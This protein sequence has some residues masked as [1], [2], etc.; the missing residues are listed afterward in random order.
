MGLDSFTTSGVLGDC[1]TAF[2][3]DREK[4]KYEGRPL[5]KSTIN[6]RD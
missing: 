2:K 4:I 5:N 6:N 3:R 1:D